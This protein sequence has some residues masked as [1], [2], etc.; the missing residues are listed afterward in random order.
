M[1]KMKRKI[2]SKNRNEKGRLKRSSEIETK[3]RKIEMKGKIETTKGI[4]KRNNG[5]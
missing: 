2:E 3:N 1:K 5:K 4:E